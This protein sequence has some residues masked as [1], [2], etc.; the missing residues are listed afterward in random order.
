MPNWQRGTKLWGESKDILGRDA[1][2]PNPS[3]N[4]VG[5]ERGDTNEKVYNFSI[6]IYY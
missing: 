2:F 6:N 4:L 1:L 3:T 5:L